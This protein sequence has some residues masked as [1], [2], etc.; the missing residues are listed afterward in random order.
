[1][2]REV[3][4]P[5]AAPLALDIL[6]VGGGI[7]GLASAIALSRAGHKILV[8]EQ[9]DGENNRREGGLRI[10][11]NM[12]KILFHWGFQ[13]QL[14]E[15]GVISHAVSLSKFETGEPLGVQLCDPEVMKETR[16]EF[17]MTT[18]KELHQMFTEIATSLGVKIRYNARVAMVYPAQR[19]VTLHSGETLSGDMILGADGEMGMCRSIVTGCEDESRQSIGLTLFSVMLD[20]TGRD[21]PSEIL[22]IINHKENPLY[23]AYGDGRTACGYPVRNHTCLVFHFFLPEQV[24]CDES[25]LVQLRRLLPKQCDPRLRMIADLALSATC[26]PMKDAPSVGDW[27]HDSGPLALVGQAAHPFIPGTLQ[28]IALGVEDGAVLGRLFSHVSNR[29]Q[30]GGFLWAFQ[31]LRQQRCMAALEL[32]SSTLWY[33]ALKNGPEQQARDRAFIAQYK[34]GES[35]FKAGP[36]GGD[37]IYWLGTVAEFAYDCEEEADSWWMRW[38]VLWERAHETGQGRLAQ[39]QDGTFD[40]SSMGV[41]VVETVVDS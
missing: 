26:I 2:D 19:Q 17:V 24:S 15:I 16:G 1:M 32:A 41:S 18:H 23:F 35:P 36:Y 20:T 31:E 7:S 10:P 8:L 40:L 39:S 9:G 27:V 12:S 34:L 4:V 6:I 33:M 30:I 5:L 28:E 14:Q 21:V 25:P 3:G 22:D 37:D 38:G 11:P 13:Y 29:E